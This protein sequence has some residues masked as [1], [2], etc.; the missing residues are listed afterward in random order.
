MSTRRYV[1]LAPQFG[2]YFRSYSDTGPATLGGG[3]Q[4]EAANVVIMHMVAYPSSFVEDVNGAHETLLV[5]TGS[6]PL[7]SFAT[8]PPSAA[9]AGPASAT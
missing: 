4:I 5:L 2:L 3:G 6:G 9:G 8:A 1:D 7:E